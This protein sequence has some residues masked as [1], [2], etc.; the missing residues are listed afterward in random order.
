MMHDFLA[1]NID[2][3]LQRCIDK[4][5]KRPRRNATPEQLKNGIPIFLE[6][7]TR[8][9][10][11]E[12]NTSAAAGAEISGGA[13]GDALALSEMGLTA[14]AH[15]TALLRLDYTVDQVVHD[16]GDLCQAI[17]D[18]AIERKVPFSIDEFR[19]LN[20]CLDN[21]IADAVTEFSAQR[22]ASI[23]YQQSANS[24]E[25]L[26]FLMHEL[27]NS[28]NV[29]RLAASALE[30]GKLTLSGATGT[31]L[32]RG[33]VSMAKLIDNSLEDVRAGSVPLPSNQMF[34][35]ADYIHEA[36]ESAQLDA[37]AR[38]SIITITDVD[39]SIYLKGNRD[40]LLGALA[41]L[42]QNAVKFTHPHSEVRL[43][44]YA[45]GDCVL[46]DVADHCGGLRNGEAETMFSPF[47][48]YS[49]DKSGLGL[50][51]SI[52]KQSVAAASGK[53]NVK[54]LPGVG[55]VFTINLPRVGA[56]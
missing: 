29:A 31:V 15:G 25:R 14:A 6:Q 39:P 27:R 33:L 56:P 16:Y 23:A 51:L 49:I 52:A 54:N 5:A 34:S 2:E 53:I 35:L 1:D 46:I 8:T 13:G 38:G 24:N 11:T 45:A 40:L 37:S 55:C 9:L 44:A 41:N 36:G 48:Q 17:T 18:L 30:G 21:A 32:K 20:R 47:T 28:L 4:V 12:Q 3:L 7:L 50:G 42:L 43:S 26:G 22:D 19:T 10:W